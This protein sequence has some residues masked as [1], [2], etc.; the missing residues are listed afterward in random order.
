MVRGLP[1][2]A[3]AALE[4]SVRAFEQHVAQEKARTPSAANRAALLQLRDRIARA[5][6]KAEPAPKPVA[7]KPRSP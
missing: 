2:D 7:E 3:K 1:P 4:P 6:A 5:L